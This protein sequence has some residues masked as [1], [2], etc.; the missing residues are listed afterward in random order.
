M[1]QTPHSKEFKE[2]ALRKLRERGSLNQ[3]SIA[4]ELNIP[5]ST[6]KG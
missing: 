4:D 3:Q 5:L 1:K 6:L 2:Q